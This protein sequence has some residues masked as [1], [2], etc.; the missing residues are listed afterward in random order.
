MGT[1]LWFVSWAISDEQSWEEKSGQEPA[2]FKRDIPH[3]SILRLKV[4]LDHLFFKK[5]KNSYMESQI[6]KAVI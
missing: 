5:K 6:Y 4:I 2:S 1:G 3:V